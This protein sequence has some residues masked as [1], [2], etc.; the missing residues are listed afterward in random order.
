MGYARQPRSAD[1]AWKRRPPVGRPTAQ[2][3][4]P[5][6]ALQRSAGNRAVTDLLQR[7]TQPTARGSN[8]FG[9][10][11]LG[12]NAGYKIGRGTHHV[13][14]QG[15]KLG[16]GGM[17]KKMSYRPKAVPGS[18]ALFGGMAAGMT[19]RSATWAPSK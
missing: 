17:L 19:A 18:L 3:A 12:A 8:R 2:P 11:K 5:L 4:H 14:S 10:V 7:K 15:K 16:V 6:V 1:E 9:R 13:T